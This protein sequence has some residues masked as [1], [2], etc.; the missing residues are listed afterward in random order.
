VLSPNK[1]QKQMWQYK[2]DCKSISTIRDR[3]W[4]GVIGDAM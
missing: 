4:K 1:Q 3:S 2:L